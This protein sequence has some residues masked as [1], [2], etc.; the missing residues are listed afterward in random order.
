MKLDAA[1]DGRRAR[2]EMTFMM[3]VVFLLLVYFIY[4]VTSM[5][6]HNAVKVDLPSAKGAP[7]APAEPP[8]VITLDRDNALAIGREPVDIP[9]AV[10]AASGRTVLI[11]ADRGASV[12]VALSLLSE[13]KNA[14]VT[15]VSFQVGGAPE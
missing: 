5:S 15:A 11:A 7:L 2:L 4:A 6:A 10:R 9:G 1:S 14:G 8:L 12:G 13:L 3:D